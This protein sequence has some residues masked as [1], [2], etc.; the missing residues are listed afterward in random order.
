V[1]LEHS[2][3]NAAGAC[4]AGTMMCPVH[5]T[6]SFHYVSVHIGLLSHWRLLNKKWH[7][8]THRVEVVV[9]GYIPIVQSRCYCSGR[10]GSSGQSG[11]SEVGDEMCLCM[12]KMIWKLHCGQH[13]F[14][15]P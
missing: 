12:L 5:F 1:P 8:F 11:D 15:L 3:H 7:K 9:V 10:S 13:M 2:N 4:T 6:A 14:R